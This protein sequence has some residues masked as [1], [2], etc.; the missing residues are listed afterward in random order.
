MLEDVDGPLCVYDAALADW[1][2]EQLHAARKA[3][4]D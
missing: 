1:A 4:E 3:E 2:I